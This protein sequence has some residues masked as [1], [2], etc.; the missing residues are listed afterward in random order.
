MPLMIR[1]KESLLHCY[2][3]HKRSSTMLS[4]LSFLQKVN[5]QSKT[6]SNRTNHAASNPQKYHNQ[7]NKNLQKL[8][9]NQNQ[10]QKKKNAG[11]KHIDPDT[12]L[13]YFKYDFGYEFGIVLP[14]EGK[15]TVT[16]TNRTIQGQRRAS[17]IEVP[18]VH[19]FTTTR[20]EN[21]FAK[22]SSS[23]SSRQGKPAGKFGTSKSVKWEPTS[24]SEFSE[25]EDA[26]NARKRQQDG[27]SAMAPPSLVI[28][29]SPSPSRWDHTTPSPLSLSPSLPSLSPRYS[30][31]TGPPS[32]VDSAGIHLLLRRY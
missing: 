3:Y 12:G 30:S 5:L 20:R 28:P 14:G 19:E 8:N 9:R 10:N 2:I 29:C 31:A 13:I 22:R 18:I 24:E 6:S 16:S 4:P 17:D 27:G 23:T 26:K 32:N 1:K 7:R 15:R 11:T 25:A 21:G